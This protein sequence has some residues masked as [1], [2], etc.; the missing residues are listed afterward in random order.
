MAEV[1]VLANDY[2]TLLHFRMELLGRLLSEG[3]Q[4]TIALP[5]HESNEAFLKLGCRVESVSLDRFGMNPL[6]D[7]RLLL[8]YLLLISRIKPNVV[9]TYTAKPNI[10]GGIACRLCRKPYICNV[11][12][13]G[14]NFQSENLIKTLMKSLQRIAYRKASRVFF[15]N[16][17]NLQYFV[18]QGIINR[19]AEQLP[20]SGV[21][22]DLHKLE[23]FPPEDGK[24]RFIT[25]SRVRKDKGFDELFEAIRAC[26]LLYDH[27]EFHLAGWYEDDGFREKIERITVECP[28]IYHGSV[29]Q[30]KVHQ[31]ITQCHCMILPSHHEGMANTLLEAAAAG[32]PCLT[33]DIPGCR[34]AVEDGQTGFLFKVR[35]S[36]SLQAAMIRFI[37]LSVE[38][39]QEMGRAGRRKMEKEFDRQ[40]VVERYLDVISQALEVQ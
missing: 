10:Y 30:A 15:Q 3:H 31:L 9:L 36:G 40:F 12:G 16:S 11:T 32:R 4:V 14:A 7:M 26:T 17:S 24:V 22:L 27:L 35:N 39:K 28:V 37:Q 2:T 25:V 6:R 19:N 21:N 13:L 38:Q 33:S 18:D 34:E 5:A 1:L 23:P 20:G 8:Q 29:P